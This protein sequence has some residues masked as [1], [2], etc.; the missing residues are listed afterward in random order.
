[1]MNQYISRFL[2]TIIVLQEGLRLPLIGESVLLASGAKLYK[3]DNERYMIG[4]YA[5]DGSDVQIYFDLY[6]LGHL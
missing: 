3:I 2:A 1:M 4:G 5:A 6:V